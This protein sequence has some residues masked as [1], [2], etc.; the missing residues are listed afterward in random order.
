MGGIGD[1]KAYPT[2]PAHQK[3]L[4]KVVKDLSIHFNVSEDKIKEEFLP[5]S[6]GLAADK[7]LETLY[8]IQGAAMTSGNLERADLLAKIIMEMKDKIKET[9]SGRRYL[10]MDEFDKMCKKYPKIMSIAA[11]AAGDVSMGDAVMHT[12]GA[13]FI[14]GTSFKQ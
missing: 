12:S 1:A 3:A 4:E 2:T 9:K 6:K 14:F 5:Q 11:N 10:P 7:T 8:Y 13:K